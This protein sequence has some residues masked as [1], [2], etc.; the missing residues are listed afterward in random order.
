MYVFK[1]FTAEAAQLEKVMS[2]A[3]KL[4]EISLSAHVQSYAKE[5]RLCLH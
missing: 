3:W 1:A 5:G 2:L 4:G